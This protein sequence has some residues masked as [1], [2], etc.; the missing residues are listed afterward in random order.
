MD[1]WHP[2]RDL[3]KGMVH[4][5]WAERLYRLPPSD[6]PQSLG[7]GEEPTYNTLCVSNDTF[8]VKD[9]LKDL[10]GYWHP[11]YKKWFFQEHPD[12]PKASVHPEPADDDDPKLRP[13]YRT[14]NLPKTVPV[15]THESVLYMLGG[16]QRCDLPMWVTP[17][18]VPLTLSIAAEAA[19]ETSS[20][21]PKKTTRTETKT[22]VTTRRGAAAAAAKN[23]NDSTIPLP[24]S[25]VA[26]SNTINRFSSLHPKIPPVENRVFKGLEKGLSGPT[27]STI[28]TIREHTAKTGS[29]ASLASRIAYTIQHDIYHSI[30]YRRE[31][32]K[33]VVSGDVPLVP[34]GVDPLT[35]P[36][37][38]SPAD[39]AASLPWD[40]EGNL[41]D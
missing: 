25:A 35:A 16:I 9:L 39:A 17:P 32:F 19:D 2:V 18:K 37:A 26:A 29:K 22:G 31:M 23:N 30:A 4:I 3:T 28:L 5:S 8:Q 27:L 41:K 40:A 11:A 34:L 21:P 38:M 14:F 7:N 15:G 12:A 24:T 13:K 36:A 6:A 1:E 10:G 20:E 33:L